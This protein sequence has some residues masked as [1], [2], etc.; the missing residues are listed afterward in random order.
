[1]FPRID[2]LGLAIG[3]LRKIERIWWHRWHGRCRQR[4]CR[5]LSLVDT[6]YAASRR[7]GA[8]AKEKYEI[9]HSIMCRYPFPVGHRLNQ[10]S[11]SSHRSLGWDPWNIK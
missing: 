4:A 2:I 11:L 5:N 3:I 1:M 6:I 9:H 10:Q 7:P 8:H